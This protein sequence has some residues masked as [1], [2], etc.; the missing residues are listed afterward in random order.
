MN[1]ARVVGALLA[2]GA[3]GAAP[4]LETHSPQ[5]RLVGPGM[6]S[7]SARAQSPVYALY[8]VGGAGQAVGIA[9]SP[10]TS[11]V[12]GGTSTALPTNRVFRDGLE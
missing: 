9:A 6:A 2:L 11:V 4:A 1:A 7:V 3:A 8:V 5:Y 12:A 10:A